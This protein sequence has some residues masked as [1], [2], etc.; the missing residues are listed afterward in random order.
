MAHLTA[1][2]IPTASLFIL[3]CSITSALPAQQITA[4]EAKFQEARQSLTG[5]HKDTEKAKR[6]LLE[7][8][9]PEKPEISV[10][11]LAYAY[12]YLG[13]IEDRAGN[14]E[15]AIAWYQKALAL[16]GP[17]EGIRNLASKGVKQPVTWILH[18]DSVEPPPPSRTGPPVGLTLARNLT[19]KDRRENFE[20][21]WGAIDHQYAHFELKSIDWREVGRRYRVRLDT[22]TSDDDFYL[23]LFQLVNELK[24]THS[25]LE[26]YQPPQLAGVPE[27][28]I[29]LVDGKPFVVAGAKAGWEILSVDGLPIAERMEALRPFLKARSSESAYRRDAARSL[30]SGE[31][32]S[33]VSVQLRSPEGKTETLRFERHAGQ[34]VR[35]PERIVPFPLTR[36]KFV[37]FGRHPSGLGYIRIESFSGREEIVDEFDRALAALRDAPGLILDIRDNPGGF[38]QPQIVGRLLRKHTL[39]GVSYIRNGPGYH[40]FRRTPIYLDPSGQWQ[41]TRP[42]ALL[43]NDGTGSASDL[44]ACELRSA[45]RV[46]TVGSTTHGNLSGV[47]TYAV[48]PCGLAVRISNGYITDAHGRPIEVNGNPPD[49]AV[50]PGILDVLNG[51]DPVL[52]RAVSLLQK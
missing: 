32:G 6:L 22:I 52:D 33:A 17:H 31:S 23:L 20:E 15:N 35:R 2:L 36:Q 14:R 1:A 16:E 8:V 39:A 46:V 7:L 50:E 51:R 47:N 48:L 24:D 21:L 43:V 11:S 40:D 26:K 12:V 28:A 42:I 5:E 37:H 25:W 3:A 34:G 9:Q 30:L 41:Y 38:G 19:A 44:F 27:L 49:V 18:L 13:Y 45:Q 4:G 10:E 29:D